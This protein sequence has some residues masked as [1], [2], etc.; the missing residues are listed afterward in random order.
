RTGATA[1]VFSGQGAQK[2]GMGAEL[3]A[4]FPVFRQALDAA[5]AALQPHVQGDLRAVIW[6]ADEALLERTEHTQPAL[7]AIEVALAALWKSWGIEPDLVIGHSVGE[8]AAAYV[9]GM[10]SLEDAARLVA[11]RGRLM[12]ALPAGGAMVALA[13]SED[14]VRAE[15]AD[16]V[17]VAAVN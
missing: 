12:G 9:A 2:L 8:L 17:S 13:A 3:Y 6:G 10:L 16:G 7:F 1:F 14:V 11:T 5:L 15:L 4:A